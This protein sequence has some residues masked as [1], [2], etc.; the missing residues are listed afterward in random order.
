[1]PDGFI[2][3]NIYGATE[4][5]GP[6]VGISCRV[7]HDPDTMHLI[8]DD[9]I[10]SEIS[11]PSR[12]NRGSGRV[13]ESLSRRSIRKPRRSFA[14]GPATWCGWPTSRMSALRTARSAAGRPHHRPLRRH[15]EIPRRLV[16]P[17]QIEDVIASS[18]D[19][20]GSVADLLDRG[21]RDSTA[22]RSPSNAAPRRR[23][24]TSGSR[25][26]SAMRARLGLR[27]DV[28]VHDEGALPRYEAKAVRVIIRESRYGSAAVA[29]GASTRWVRT[30]SAN[31]GRS[32]GSPASAWRTVEQR[33]E[34]RTSERR[35][36]GLRADRPSASSS[37]SLVVDDVHRSAEIV[38]A[39]DDRGRAFAVHGQRRRIDG[40]R[41]VDGHP[42]RR[43]RRRSRSAR[44]RRRPRA[45]ETL[46]LVRALDV[47]R[48]ESPVGADRRRGPRANSTVSISCDRYRA[49]EPAAVF[50]L[51]PPVVA[52]VRRP[53]AGSVPPPCIRSRAAGRGGR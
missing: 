52:G 3:H 14:G 1:M 39:A 2:A 9:S 11:T 23:T 36:R 21:D 34:R 44:T 47:R 5:G 22:R 32:A 13:G 42:R 41:P 37:A 48:R 6:N 31:V 19:R 17:S 10:M 50:A 43:G 26:R 12:S 8:N 38:G 4:S 16:Y 46:A 29:D 15:A 24:T 28:E 49:G 51:E 27:F 20:E 45:R 25:L 40:A 53:P 30:P 18:R 7:S 35:S 33:D